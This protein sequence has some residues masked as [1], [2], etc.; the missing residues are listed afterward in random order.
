MANTYTQLYIHIVFAVKYRQCLLHMRFEEDVFKY[1][2]GI[3][4][5]KGHKLIAI[6]GMPDH[7]HIFVGLKPKEAI[8]DLVRGIKKDSSKFSNSKNWFNSKFNWQ[9]GFGAFSYAHSQISNVANYIANQ[10]AHHKQRAFREEYLELLAK[11]QIESDEKY[12][13]EWINDQ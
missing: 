11:F 10:K 6:N 7:I 1:I 4:Q 13:F 2:T 8:S 9:G 12:Q 3:V 5:T